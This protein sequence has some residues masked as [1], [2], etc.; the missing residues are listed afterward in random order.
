MIRNRNYICKT[1]VPLPYYIAWPRWRCPITFSTLFWLEVSHGFHQTQEGDYGIM[2]E[3]E[4]SEVTLAFVCYS[5]IHLSF[6]LPT[7][8]CFEHTKVLSF[9][10][11]YLPVPNF[12]VHMALLSTLSIQPGCLLHYCLPAQGLVTQPEWSSSSLHH[13]PR[14]PPCPRHHHHTH[15]SICNLRLLWLYLPLFPLCWGEASMWIFH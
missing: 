14:P 4:P 10:Q 7:I 13:P 8:P 11:T 3:C 5:S 6:S 1:P 2:P 15:T 9:P 12:P